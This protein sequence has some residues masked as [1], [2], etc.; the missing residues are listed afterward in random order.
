MC[1]EMNQSNVYYGLIAIR[2]PYPEI[3]ETSKPK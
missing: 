3:A 1:R 2:D